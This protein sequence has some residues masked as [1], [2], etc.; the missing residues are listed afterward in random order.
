VVVLHEADID[1]GF[2][3]ELAFVVA[4]EEKAAVITEYRGLED[5]YV[6][7]IG[8]NDVHWGSVMGDE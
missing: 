1:A 5:Q 8:R 3:D 4:F 7:D 6:G 2:F